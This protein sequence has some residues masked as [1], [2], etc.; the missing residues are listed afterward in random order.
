MFL[1]WFDDTKKKPVE[2]KILEG[3]Q[4]YVERFGQTPNVCLVNPGEAVQANGITVRP[5]AYVRPNNYWLGVEAASEPAP[6]RR[7]KRAA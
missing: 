5:T 3:V 2:E 4:R 1:L 6:R 7:T